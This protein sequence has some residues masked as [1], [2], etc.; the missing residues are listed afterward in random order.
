MWRTPAI[1]ALNH[2]EKRDGTGYLGHFNLLDGMV[3]A[4]YENSDGNPRPKKGKEIPLFGWIVALA[5]V[6]DAFSSPR[7]YQERW[8]ESHVLD[9]LKATSGT[10]FDPE[11]VDTSFA[12]L[13]TVRSISERYPDN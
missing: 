9:E 5:D 8:D 7:A 12:C 4:G 2:H 11:V 6:H 1:A 3:M 10:H 13:D